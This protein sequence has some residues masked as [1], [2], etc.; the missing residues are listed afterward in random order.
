MTSVLF[1]IFSYPVA[2]GIMINSFKKKGLMK[3][4]QIRYLHPCPL[5]IHPVIK[6]L[7]V[8]VITGGSMAFSDSE[9]KWPGAPRGTYSASGFK[10]ND[11]FVI[12]EWDMVIVRQV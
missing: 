10:N 2:G 8:T 1:S 6:R 11:M 7:V 12:P 4:H 3:L 9:Y 5:T